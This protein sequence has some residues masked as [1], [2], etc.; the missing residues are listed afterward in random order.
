MQLSAGDKRIGAS[1]F[2]RFARGGLLGLALLGLGM[3][4]PVAPTHAQVGSTLK[5]VQERGYVR[6]G[7]NDLGSPLASVDEDGQWQ[8]FFVD[9]CRAV[10]TAVTGDPASVDF[11]PVS[12]ADGFDAVRNGGIDLLA[13]ASTWTLPRDG[14]GLTF[15]ALYLF[16]G[17][18]FLVHRPSGVASVKELTGRKVCVRGQSS[19]AAANLTAIDRELGLN[20]E[21]LEYNSIDGAFRAFFD[22]QCD[23]VTADA[24]VLASMRRKLAAELKDYRILEER[25]SKNPLAPV[26]RQ[27]D[28]QWADIVRWVIFAMI[29]AEELGVDSGNV[30]AMRE[31][32]RREIKAL[33]GQSV[34][35]GAQLGLDRE[36]IFRVVRE[37]GNYGEVFERNL[38]KKLALDRGPNALWTKGGLLWAPP[39]R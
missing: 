16:D 25:I 2:H 31:N 35:P 7:V 27:D 18:G 11:V 21:V 38:G 28:P 33:L 23:A 3:A 6:C 26:V 12:D 1:P 36:W 24:M 14:Q 29:G 8:G 39:I 15:A 20:L 37:V 17:Q 34:H 32:D 4:L 9:L 13:Q 10:A 30:V 22:G 5:Q 19:M